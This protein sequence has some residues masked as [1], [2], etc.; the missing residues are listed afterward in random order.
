[1]T[2]RRYRGP[3]GAVFTPGRLV[4][5]RTIQDYVKRGEWVPVDEKPAPAKRTTKAA[6]EK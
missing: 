6:D 5:E 3:G 1:M 2:K 4:S